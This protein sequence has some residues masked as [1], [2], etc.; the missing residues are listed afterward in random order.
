MD[1]FLYDIGLRHERVKDFSVWKKLLTFVWDEEIPP[2]KLK[3][4]LWLILSL[5]EKRKKQETLRVVTIA[6][7]FG[8]LYI[9]HSSI[10]DVALIAKIVRH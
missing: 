4:Y 10:Y 7:I 2:R 1:W 9:T 8:G 5:P 6:M 3:K